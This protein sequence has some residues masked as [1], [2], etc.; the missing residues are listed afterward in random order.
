M[1][2]FQISLLIIS[3]VIVCFSSIQITQAQTVLDGVYAK[4][5]N[6][7]RVD[8]TYA[9][10][11]EADVMWAKRTWR[12]IDLKQKRNLPLY[13]PKEPI[14]AR[15]SMIDVI[16]A[17]AWAEDPNYD[18]ELTLFSPGPMQD[19][20]RFS[21]KLTMEEKKKLGGAGLDTVDQINPDTGMPEQKV[22]ENDFRTYEVMEYLIKEDWFFDRQRSVLDVRII[23]LCPI[24]HFNKEGSEEV[25]KEKICWVYFPELRPLIAT[26]EVF[27]RFNDAE[28]KTYDDIFWKRLFSSYIIQETNVYDNRLISE[29][30][31]GLDALLEAEKIKDKIRLTE[32]DLWEY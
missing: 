5:H 31:V 32:H 17:A 7:N 3:I 6:P 14:N 2:T 30:R 29:Y 24:R 15:K 20:D 25:F 21:V 11:R 16:M 22:I 23:G 8:I 12:I 19:D 4:E 27:N 26:R 13:Y 10:L 9:H 18:G 1:K 28:R